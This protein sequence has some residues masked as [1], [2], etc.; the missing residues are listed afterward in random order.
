MLQG[1]FTGRRSWHRR[2]RRNLGHHPFDIEAFPANAFIEIEETG[3]NG[4]EWTDEGPDDEAEG[5]A[6]GVREEGLRA[7]RAQRDE[8]QRC[9]NGSDHEIEGKEEDEEQ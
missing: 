9:L 8:G 2:R 7:P 3:G 6:D 4:P 5:E 1:A